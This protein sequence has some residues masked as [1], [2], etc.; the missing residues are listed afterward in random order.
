MFTGSRRRQKESDFSSSEEEYE[1]NASKAK[2]SSHHS[3]SAQN[4]RGRRSKSVSL[5]TEAE[6]DLNEVD[7]YQNWSTHSAEIAKLSQDLAKDLAILAKEIHDVAG[8]G[9]SPSSGPGATT[10]PSP[11]PNTPAST[12]SAREETPSYPFLRGVQ[13]SQ[14]VHH[15]PEASLNYQK[16]PPGSSVVSDLDANMNEPEPGSKQ[17]RPWN[18]EEV[19][20]DNLMLNPVSQLSQAIRENTEQLAEKMKVL[21]QNKAEVWEEIEAKINAENEVP[22]LKTSNKEITSILKELRRVQRQLEV[23]NTIVEP[24]GSL[25]IAAVGTSSLG[26]SSLSMKAPDDR[27]VAPARPITRPERPITRPERPITR[28]ERPITRPECPITRPERPITRPERPI[29]RPECP[30]TRPDRPITR[31]ERPITRPERPITRPERPITRPERPITRPERPITRPECP[32]TRPERPITRP[33]RPITRPERPIT[34]PERPIT[35]PERPITRPERPITRPERPITRPE[36]PITRPEQ[37]S[38]PTLDRPCAS[39]PQH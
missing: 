4:P 20:L 38:V 19:I 5:E 16:V 21:F 18:R 13:P 8:D 33:E 35:R 14:L 9:D 11:L 17:R 29:T 23:I 2:R 34:R 3:A 10:S 24:G 27:L 25:Q 37:A 6:D 28:P 15:I 36:R 31:P 1:M 26:T 30:I 39:T 22:I 12:I 7:P 32:I